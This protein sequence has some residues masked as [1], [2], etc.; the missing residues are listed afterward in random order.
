[1]HL[2][3]GLYLFLVEYEKDEAGVKAYCRNVMWY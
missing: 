1:M 2:N 3:W